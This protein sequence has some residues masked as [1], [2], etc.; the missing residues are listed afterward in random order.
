M[1]GRFISGLAFAVAM[2]GLGAAVTRAADVVA[3]LGGTYVTTLPSGA[4][5][6]VDGTYVGHSPIVV[7]GVAAGRHGM[8]VTKAGY[9]SVE[10]SIVVAP[11]TLVM[12]SLRL[13]PSTRSTV[14][15][16][17]GTL[18]L[19]GVPPHA[20]VTVDGASLAAPTV[21]LAAGTHALVVRSPHGRM[22]RTFAIYPGTT[23]G[24]LLVEARASERRS[25]VV[26][27]AEDYLP[28]D[29]FAVAGN[30]ITVRYLGHTILAHFGD[31]HV[32]FDGSSL[33]F[34]SAPE[35][36]GGKLY[37]PLELLEKVTGD[38]SKSR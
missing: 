18:A 29:S 23:T 12:S 35:S 1:I 38:V 6:W 17:G 22:T 9:D 24:V 27:L 19:R 10:T 28:T 15:S 21:S 5:V 3:V 13:A 32:R 31:P 34:D 36:I 2:L 4:D 14:A 7:D 16:E 25:A 30:R 26:A 11:G 33:L 20:T 37:L 8:T